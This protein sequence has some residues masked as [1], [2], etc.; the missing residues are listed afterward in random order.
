ML[1]GWLVATHIHTAKHCVC[2]H[3]E[4]LA[5]FSRGLWIED[6]WC[7]YILNFAAEMKCLTGCFT[8]VGEVRYEQSLCV[9]YN[10]W[11]RGHEMHPVQLVDLL[12]PGVVQVL[13]DLNIS[14][15]DLQKNFEIMKKTT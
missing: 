14:E 12:G 8:V 15:I 5:G 2:T 4:I 11:V 13:G 7:E 3:I 1:S 10:D 6:D 9:N